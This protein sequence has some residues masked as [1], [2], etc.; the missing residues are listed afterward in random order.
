M[1]TTDGSTDWR[2]LREFVAVD[3]TQSYVLSWEVVS[4]TLMVDVDL[5][6]APEH[7]FYEKPRPAQRVCIRPA[8]LEF[9]YCEGILADRVSKSTSPVT[10][11][12]RL[13]LGAIEGFR[14]L[15]DGRNEI[16]GEFGVVI[17]DAERPLLR[18]KEP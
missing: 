5:Q 1:T 11:A 16:R 18:L 13:G 17:I 9:P 15:A 4:E 14:R 8:V 3:L 12:S 10:V 2:S 6:L 7:P